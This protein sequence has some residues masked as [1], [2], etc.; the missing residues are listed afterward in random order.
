MLYYIITAVAA[1]IVLYGMSKMRN[2]KKVSLS[3]W[4]VFNF[5]I[6]GD[7]TEPPKELTPPKEV[8]PSSTDGAGPY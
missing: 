7:G 6:E 2:L 8:E 1:V 5:T 3:V 4:K